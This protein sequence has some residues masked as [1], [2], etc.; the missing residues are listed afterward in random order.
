MPWQEVVKVEL[1][2]L[3]AATIESGKLSMSEACREFKIS[4]TC[5]Y[6]WLKR[7]RLEGMAGLQ[8][9]SRRPHHIGRSTPAPV[10]EA[11]LKE[12]GKYPFWGARKIK[13]RLEMQGITPPSE[14]T[15]NRILK[16]AGLS[17][18]LAKPKE[19]IQRFQRSRPNALWQMDHKGRVWGNWNK[20]VVPFCVLDDA[21]RYC[22][23]LWSLPDK[24]LQSTWSALWDIFGEVGLPESILSDNA[25]TF[26]GIVGPSR[27]EVRLLLLG[28]R[29]LHGRIMHPQTQGKVERFNGTL[30]REVLQN[31]RF[32]SPGELTEQFEQFRHR[33]NFDR[34][35]EALGMDTPGLHYRPSPRSR[36]DRIPSVHYPPGRLLRKVM[37]G[38]YISYR[39]RRVRVGDGLI[40]Y[41]VEVRE[42]NR[43]IEVYFGPHR[44]LGTDLRERK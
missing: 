24:G 31:G 42:F 27:M 25:P 13:K 10:E 30:Q 22:L 19:E 1:R 5:G 3:F 2:R 20:R 35:H 36:P 8:D 32:S 40:G 37:S 29:F 21:T 39:G 44:I 41:W 12:R 15:I 23:G 18:G 26:R 28:V 14:R 16:R 6:K 9:R 33:Y 11:V 17:D 4:R 43:G 34:P 7:Y 38:G